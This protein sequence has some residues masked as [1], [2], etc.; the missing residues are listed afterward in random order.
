MRLTIDDK[1]TWIGDTLDYMRC[2]ENK[3]YYLEWLDGKEVKDLSAEDVDELFD[4]MV[5][6]DDIDLSD[7]Y[8]GDIYGW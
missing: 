7:L 3:E 1:R 5:G 2:K 4:T 8:T 6:N